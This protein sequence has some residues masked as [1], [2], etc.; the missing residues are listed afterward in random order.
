MRVF[1]LVHYYYPHTQSC[2]ALF[3]DLAI[4]LRDMGHEVILAAPDPSL[5]APRRI[6]GDNGL[7]VVRIRSGPFQDVSRTRRAWNEWRLP[8]IMWRRAGDYFRDN[9]CDLIVNMS[10]T[11][12]FGPLV[13]R[14]KRLWQCRNYLVLRDIFPQWAV[15]SGLIE[16]GGA[17][18]RFFRRYETLLY[19]TADVIGITSERD[20]GHFSAPGSR[21]KHVVE[22][23]PS[24]A[25]ADGREV[26]ETDYRNQL[27]LRDKVVFL[28]GGNLGS[29]QEAMSIVRLAD[30]LRDESS[31]RFLIVGAGS[32]AARLRA[33]ARALALDNLQ[34]LAPVGF[35]RYMGM[36]SEF[37]VGMITLNRHLRTHNHPVKMFDYMYFGKPILAAINTG[38]DLY[39]ILE[40][41]E[42]GL[43]CW[44]GEDKQLAAHARRLSTQA[45]LRQRLGSNSRA[46]LETVFSPRRA[47]EQ[48]LSHG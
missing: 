35:D 42:A 8:A 28:Y 41:H 40:R 39:E 16:D 24:W 34:F 11:I 13:A 32:E 7:T 44:N 29:A 18:H 21:L 6:T 14:L 36:V 15:D 30:S 47:A 2:A 26:A 9:R 1:L 37:D 31:A 19:E 25:A 3:H 20:L 5:D 48:I 43:V 17:I 46:L 27:G 4:T 22:V 23:L 45:D 33:E 38:N 12:F 10:P